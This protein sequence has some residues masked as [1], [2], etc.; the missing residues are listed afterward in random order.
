MAV[1]QSEKKF[2][3]LPLFGGHTGGFKPEGTETWPDSRKIPVNWVLNILKYI[4]WATASTKF[5]F[6]VLNS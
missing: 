2:G 6:F 1:T 3:A 5:F 4:L